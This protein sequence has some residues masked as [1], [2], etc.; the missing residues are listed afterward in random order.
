MQTHISK[1]SHLILVRLTLFASLFGMLNLV[2]C[3]S[4]KVSYDFDRQANYSSYKTYAYTPEV[5]TFL[6]DINRGRITA[7]IDNEMAAKGFTKSE[8]PDVWI[9][10]KITAEKK[11]SATSTP[12]YYGAGYGY[13]W[14]G[15][16]STSTINV[17]TYVEG[18]LFVDMIDVSKKQLVWQGRAVGTLDPEA[19]A[20]K[21]ESNINYAVQQI[22]TKYPP[23]MK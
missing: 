14:G 10:L 7:A 21:R 6:D 8:N 17:D 3:S 11:V 15:G 20:S 16:F 12:N 23:K 13:R 4:I 5:A 2:S 1:W 9:D 19:S 18:T 22:F